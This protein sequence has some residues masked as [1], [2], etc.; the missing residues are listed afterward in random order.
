MKSAQP[1]DVLNP[2]RVQEVI[3][4]EL[5]LETILVPGTWSVLRRIKCYSTLPKCFLFFFFHQ[6]FRSDD[7]ELKNKL[8]I[9]QWPKTMEIRMKSLSRQK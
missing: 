4:N 1:Y 5:V 8:D 7:R 6:P 9:S 2:G 3:R